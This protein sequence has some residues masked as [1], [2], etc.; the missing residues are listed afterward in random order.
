MVFI[1]PSYDWQ[2]LSICNENQYHYTSLNPSITVT[3]VKPGNLSVTQSNITLYCMRHGFVPGLNHRVLFNVTQ[4]QCTG[5]HNPSSQCMFQNVTCLVM[6][7]YGINTPATYSTSRS[8]CFRS[9]LSLVKVKILFFSIFA[10]AL[11]SSSII[12]PEFAC[13]WKWLWK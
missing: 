11:P 12:N 3:T 7:T 1:N 10:T 8:K 2:A 6:F 5:M 9:S 4:S 13:K